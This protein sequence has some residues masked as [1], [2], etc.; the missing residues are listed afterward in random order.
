MSTEA[1]QKLQEL[2]S[3]LPKTDSHEFSSVLNPEYTRQHL[4]LSLM[5]DSLLF[6]MH[7]AREARKLANSWRN[8]N[9]GAS[10]ISLRIKAGAEFSPAR[11]QVLEGVNVKPEEESKINIHAE[12]QA[13]QKARDYGF[14]AVSMLVVVGEP[15]PDQ[16]TGRESPTLHPCGLCREFM[17]NDPLIDNNNTLIA[18]VLPSFQ[19]IEMY[20]LQ[21]LRDLHD[22]KPAAIA[23]FDLPPLHLFEPI[24]TTSGAAQPPDDE[25]TEEELRIWH[26]TVGPYLSARRLGYKSPITEP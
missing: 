8:F 15:Q 24:D 6:A 25:E 14:N 20:D 17:G 13:L 16:Q 21:A 11:F 7:R 5:P 22:E 9:V 19:T 23:R 26:G 3:R 1:T 2:I 10:A 12:Q 4:V 18:S